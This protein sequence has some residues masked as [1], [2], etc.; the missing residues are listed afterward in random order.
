MHALILIPVL[1]S[2]PLEDATQ[3]MEKASQTLQSIF[4]STEEKLTIAKWFSLNKDGDLT[5]LSAA[6]IMLGKATLVYFGK[7]WENFKDL[8][9]VHYICEYYGIQRMEE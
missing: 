5:E 7:G 6:I 3:H 1:D 4:A 9:T 2:M 8:Q